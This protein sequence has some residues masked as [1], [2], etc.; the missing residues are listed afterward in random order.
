MA[1]EIILHHYW[2]SPF[3]EKVRLLFGIKGVAWRGVIQPVIMPKPDLIPLTGGYR[4]IPV[5]Q[6]GADIFIDSAAIMAEIERRHPQ[7]RVIRGADWALNAW[8][9]RILFQPTVAIIFGAIG[10]AIDPAFV[11]DREA[12]SGRPFDAAA[13]KAAGP[14]AR[15][16]FRAALGWLEAQLGDGP[17]VGGERPSLGDI[18]FWLNV[19]FYGSVLKAQLE[20]D[21]SDFPQA[22]AWRER[23]TAIGCGTHTE[24]SPAEALAIAAANEPDAALQIAHDPADPS[25]LSPGASVTMCA[26]DYGCDPI[27]GSLVSANP[28]AIVISRQTPELGR[29]NLHFPRAGYVLR[30]G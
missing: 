25:G 24:M 18:A 28:H 13:M 29:L 5:M 2:N 3:S 1:D 16:Q 19:W 23:L 11:K 26:D 9:D 14:S 4:R 22:A 21:I 12:M 8:A 17:Y 30:A 6:V 7:P 15:G 20:Q 10:G 27:A